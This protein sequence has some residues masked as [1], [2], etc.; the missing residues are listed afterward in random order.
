MKIVM[1]FV[2]IGLLAG[3]AA[4]VTDPGAYNSIR[5]FA[6]EDA[7]ANVPVLDRFALFPEAASSRELEEL[8]FET[9]SYGKQLILRLA[10]YCVAYG[11]N[12]ITDTNDLFGTR[13]PPGWLD[14]INAVAKY[15]NKTVTLDDDLRTMKQLGRGVG[16]VACSENRLDIRQ[17]ESDRHD[18]AWYAFFVGRAEYNSITTSSYTGHYFLV[19][20]R[21]PG[22]DSGAFDQA[23]IARLLA[24]QPKTV[25]LD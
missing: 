18:V 22:V 11:L 4:T 6:L 15:A 3:C 21:R 20:E 1:S 9:G 2:A 5:E 16:F 8:R 17:V 12:P 13:R 10:D 14:G 23:V 7:R 25:K 24:Y 19:L